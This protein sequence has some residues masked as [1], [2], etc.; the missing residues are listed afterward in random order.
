[1]TAD[2]LVLTLR[3]DPAAFARLD[4]LRARHFPPDRNLVPAHVT[5]FHAL[6]GDE[7]DAVR[8]AL[9]DVCSTTPAVP[10]LFPGVRSLGRGVAVAVDA[11]E[12]VRLRKVLAAR[13]AGWLSPQ[14]RQGYRPHVTVQNKV[15]PADARRTFERLAAGW[16][17][18]AGRGEG[19]DL[20]HYR[21]GP[22][23]PADG[24]DFGA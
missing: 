6:P 22:W 8:S 24:F 19:L 9:A 2:P 16:E 14:D 13:W 20:W 10:L 12:L 7:I 3:L 4:A 17:P 5:L 21:S 23:E 11:P 18:F 1:V 15:D